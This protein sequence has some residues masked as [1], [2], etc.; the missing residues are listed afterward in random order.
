[1]NQ[2]EVV[3]TLLDQA[4]IEPGFTELGNHEYL[5]DWRALCAFYFFLFNMQN[6]YE[7]VY[8]ALFPFNVTARIYKNMGL[9]LSLQN[10]EI[11]GLK[12]NSL[13]TFMLLL[14]LS[15][16]AFR[17]FV[18]SIIQ[19]GDT[20]CSYL[21]CLLSNFDFLTLKIMLYLRRT[22]FS[23][24]QWGIEVISQLVAIGGWCTATNL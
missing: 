8:F 9:F 16:T 23:L 20:P 6:I 7:L 18:N 14:G 13:F 3:E 22:F 4:K 10:A 5:F 2:K 19:D 15:F 21:M 12:I 24:A 11:A 1:M 17:V